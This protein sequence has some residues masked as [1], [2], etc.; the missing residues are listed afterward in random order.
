LL[1]PA[2][3]VS[4]AL[5]LLQLRRAALPTFNGARREVFGRERLRVCECADEE[6]NLLHGAVS[7]HRYLS[8]N[9][10]YTVAGQW[11]PRVI[12]D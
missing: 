11:P 10:H 9:V 12:L 2:T 7:E 4:G 5:S 6:E 1:L 3:N 8:G